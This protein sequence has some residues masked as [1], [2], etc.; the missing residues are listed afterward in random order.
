MINIMK[1]HMNKGFTLLESIFSLF[2]VSLSLSLLFTALPLLKKMNEFEVS[3]EEEIALA[4]IRETLL[5]ASDIE[6]SPF[7]L[8][9]YTMEDMVTLTL[10]YDRIVRHDGY[11]IFMDGLE[12]SEF[13]EKNH[14]IYL[15]YRR[16]DIEKERFLVCE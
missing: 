12:E 5:F 15:R 8:F 13:I 9:F 7:E 11:L 16:N 1:K 6:Y 14:C 2:I 3:I 10:E 4:K